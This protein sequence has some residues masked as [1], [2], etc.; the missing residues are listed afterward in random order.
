MGQREGMQ[1]LTALDCF[2]SAMKTSPWLQDAEIGEEFKQTSERIMAIMLAADE[3]MKL[4]AKGNE[5]FGRK[6]FRETLE[7]WLAARKKL[8]KENLS[9]HHVAVLCSNIAICHKNMG[10]TAKCRASCEDGL[11]H[12]AAGAIHTKLKHHLRSVTNRR[13]LDTLHLRRQPRS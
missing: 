10:D 3:A 6:K 12:Y 8:E 11:R 7:H 4:K 13:Q 5:A 1:G 9:G 2:R